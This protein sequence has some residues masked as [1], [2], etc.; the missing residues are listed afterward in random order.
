LA[1]LDPELQDTE[2]LLLLLSPTHASYTS[3][4]L[5]SSIRREKKIATISS[6][7]FGAQWL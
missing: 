5:L 2:E 4:M 3:Y 6:T 7:Q 1:I